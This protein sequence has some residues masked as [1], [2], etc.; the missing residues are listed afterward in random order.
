MIG[1]TAKR[2][3]YFFLILKRCRLTEAEKSVQ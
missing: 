1:G 2:K 3:A